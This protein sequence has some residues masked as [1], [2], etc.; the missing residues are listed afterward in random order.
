MPGLTEE[1]RIVA[2]DPVV[3]ELYSQICVGTIAAGV[4]VPHSNY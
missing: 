2:I 4:V 3:E 1:A